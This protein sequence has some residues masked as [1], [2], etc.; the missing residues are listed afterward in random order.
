MT[1]IPVRS[2]DFQPE[3]NGQN[4]N[5][6][7]NQTD[8]SQFGLVDNAKNISVSDGDA[9]VNSPAS[10]DANSVSSNNSPADMGQTNAP[11]SQAVE[12]APADSGEQEINDS[13]TSSNSDNSEMPKEQL[14]A[15]TKMEEATRQ[16]N[17]ALGD[18]FNTLGDESEAEDLENTVSDSAQPV[19]ESAP[20]TNNTMSSTAAEAQENT[21]QSVDG[22]SQPVSSQENIQN[23]PT[24]PAQ[25]D[26]SDTDANTDNNQS[27]PQQ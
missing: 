20:Q 13:F 3:E 10:V 19:Q 17:D 22:A 11:T 21:P 27:G 1:N 8:D 2:D 6:A 12:P 5:Q 18:M 14:E 25:N 7:N 23:D 9:S 24:Q 4:T 26:V 15:K 16:A